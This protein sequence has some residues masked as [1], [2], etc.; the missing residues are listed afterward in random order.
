MRC[1][2]YSF[3]IAIIIIILI[4]VSYSQ[5]SRQGGGWPSRVPLSAGGAFRGRYSFPSVLA[6]W[7]RNLLKYRREENNKRKQKC[8]KKLSYYFLQNEI[9]KLRMLF[10]ISHFV[11]HL[12]DGLCLKSC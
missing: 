6:A 7:I 8:Q 2:S 1:Y 5:L 3:I 11:K 9:K 10:T 4:S 12:L